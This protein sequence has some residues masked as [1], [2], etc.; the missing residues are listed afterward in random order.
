MIGKRHNT[1]RCT[2]KEKA[3]RY[4]QAFELRQQYMIDWT[5]AQ[6]EKLKYDS[7]FFWKIEAI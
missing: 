2:C 7:N 4:E 1:D 3:R 6:A 5:K